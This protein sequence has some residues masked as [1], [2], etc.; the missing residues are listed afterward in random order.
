MKRNIIFI[1]LSFGVML[2]DVS[3]QSFW[4]EKQLNIPVRDTAGNLIKQPWVG[5]LNAC[6]MGEIDLNF[7]GNKDLV[8]YDQ[9]AEKLF[10]FVN[11]GLAE[12]GVNDYRYTPEYE[13]CFPSFKTWFSMTDFNGDALPDLFVFTPP[14][15]ITL[16]KNV[17]QNSTVKFELHTPRV[18]AKMYADYLDIYCNEADFPAFVDVDGDGDLDI[19][20][21]EIPQ[22]GTGLYY[23]R[24]QSK[25]AD[26]L[27]FVLE[28]VQWGCFEE[29]SESNVIVLN[30]CDK[31]AR[32]TV[33][34]T[35]ST[36]FIVNLNNDSLQDLLLADAGYPNMIALYNS[37]TREKAKF[38]YMDTAFPRNS[39]PVKLLNCPAI[40]AIDINN[41]NVKE[42]LFSPYSGVN[43]SIE[44]YASNWV[45]KNM[46]TSAMPDY[47]LISKRF[48]Q[49]EMLDFGMD[50]YPTIVDIDGDGLLDIVAGNYGKIDTAWEEYGAWTS[51]FV[52][53]LTVLR[54]IGTPT[55]PEFQLGA[56]TFSPGLDCSAAAP[57]FGDIDNDGV[58]ELL[59]GTERGEIRLYKR[60][61]GY[62][63]RG[64]GSAALNTSHLAPEY[65]LV[66]ANILT[67]NVGTFVAPQL[68]DLDGDGLL[69]LIVGD[70]FQNR[71][72]IKGNIT[73]LRNTGTRE[74]PEFSLITDSLGG[75][76]VRNPERS[77]FGYSKPCFFKDKLGNIHLFCGN[78]DGK[79][80]HYTDIDNNLSGQ[81]TRLGD[82]Q[83][84]A[85]G[86][87]TAVSVADFNNDG[88][89][90]LVVGNHRGGL[91]IFYG[92]TVPANVEV[93]EMNDD[94]SLHVYPNPVHDWL[95]IRWKEPCAMQYEIVDMQG[96]TVRPMQWTQSAQPISVSALSSGLYILKIRIEN[97]LFT[98]KIVK[99]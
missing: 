87:H 92:T 97:R 43:F 56:I 94:P 86:S 66:D 21:F 70:M 42:L 69:D 52:S 2:M 75:V 53:E 64:A 61:T 41:D 29:N 20:N 58:L 3:A 54:N 99:N 22:K 30:A 16:Y 80:L 33:R 72:R 6:I 36:I 34:H 79:V 38:T 25:H 76:D 98:Q 1:L 32:P 59:I 85:E 49:D 12:N 91:A 50:A 47:Q 88:F 71:P 84:I 60:G 40:S 93:I 14:S 73:Y 67:Q 44:S 95:Y 7:D 83:A 51:R 17:S 18:Q 5:G 55:A 28:D 23:Y 63:V 48:L 31:P 57:A 68:Y 45:Y 35:G 8:V 15:Y 19:L 74:S 78:E 81:F 9:H 77:N 10:A 96:R 27:D 62:G 13:S 65:E 89:L 82:V 37:G 46:S 11:Y 24:N 39:T 26:S 90:D 4:F